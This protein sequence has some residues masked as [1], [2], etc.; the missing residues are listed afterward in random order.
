MTMATIQQHLRHNGSDFHGDER[1]FVP[2]ARANADGD[3]DADAGA[4]CGHGRRPPGCAQ[5]CS[6]SC[7]HV[8]ALRGRLPGADGAERVRT[9]AQPP[10][11]PQSV[12]GG[13]LGRLG[14]L[15]GECLKVLGVGLG[16]VRL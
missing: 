16:R 10:E 8:A 1:W 5:G 7:G 14:R 6:A 9:G 12:L 11:V 13:F 4:E 3:G 2:R 15:L